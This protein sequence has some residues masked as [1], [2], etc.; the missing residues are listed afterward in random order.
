MKKSIALL[1]CIVTASTIVVSNKISTVDGNY[2]VLGKILQD[3][4]K[5]IAEKETSISDKLIEK[6]REISFFSEMAE[7]LQKSKERI[8]IL[9]LQVQELQYQISQQNKKPKIF[10]H[11]S[12]K[13]LI[14]EQQ[15]EEPSPKPTMSEIDTASSGEPINLGK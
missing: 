3:Q 13:D 15:E 4:D 5:S 7:T 12:E 1:Y 2:Y 6:V 10:V 14:A 11:K 8:E 9:E